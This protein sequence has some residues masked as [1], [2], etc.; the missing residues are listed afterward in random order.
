MFWQSILQGFTS[1]TNWEIWVGMLSV[2]LVQV[3]FV[4]A[5]GRLMLGGES[6]ARTAMGCFL[7]ATLGPIV[8]C[9]AVT[10]FIVFLLP[11]LLLGRG[12]TPIDTATALVT[13]VFF[14]YGL[15]ALAIVSVLSVVPV[16]GRLISKT[17][18][19]PTFLQGII[20][21]K[22]I[23]RILLESLL[24]ES[25]VSDNLYPGFWACVGYFII[26]FALIMV[27]L[28]LVSLIREKIDPISYS[29]ERH[30]GNRLG[31]QFIAAQFLGPM[32]GIIPLLMYGKYVALSVNASLNG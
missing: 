4:L 9:L 14:T 7:G 6:G 13:P 17:P 8:Q 23:S 12:F 22:P 5:V 29:M 30:G 10:A 25:K 19:L 18:G 27:T 21:F 15:L 11:A 26:G 1:L 20:I 28:L 3:I 24:G 32:L 2:G 16:V 31:F